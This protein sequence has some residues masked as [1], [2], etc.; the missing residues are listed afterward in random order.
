MATVMVL[1]GYLLGSLPCGYLAGRWLKGID[2]RQHGSGSTGA[3][4]TPGACC[5]GCSTG[6]GSI[7]GQMA[8]VA[9]SS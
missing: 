6:A 1:I 2:I 8:S 5:D 7:G 4:A 9:R 3:G